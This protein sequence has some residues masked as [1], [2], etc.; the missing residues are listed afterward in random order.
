MNKQIFIKHTFD[1]FGQDLTIRYG[2]EEL[3]NGYDCYVKIT[4]HL[5][6]TPSNFIAYVRSKFK[7]ILNEQKQKIVSEFTKQ[8]KQEFKQQLTKEVEEIY[9]K[10]FEIYTII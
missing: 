7:G 6:E 5:N 10:G 8:R 2:K 1:C 4:K 3:I 9:G